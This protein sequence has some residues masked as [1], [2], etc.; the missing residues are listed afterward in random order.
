MN[1]NGVYAYIRGIGL[2]NLRP[3]F[4]GWFFN[5]V[6]SLLVYSGSYVV[7]AHS[8]GNNPA[9]ADILERIGLLNFLVDTSTNFPGNLSLLLFFAGVIVLL[10]LPASIFAAGGIYMVFIEDDKTTFTN[11]I[12]YS[13]ENFFRMLKMFLV[14]LFNWFIA[15][16]IPGL[17][18]W[19][20]YRLGLLSSENGKMIFLFAWVPL[21][22]LAWTV[23]TVIYDFSRIFKLIEDRNIFYSF[24]KALLFTFSNKINILIIFLLYAVSLGLFYLVHVFLMRLIENLVPCVF[25]FVVYQGFIITRYF[26]KIILMRAQVEYLTHRSPRDT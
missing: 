1:M 17:V 24:K 5:L 23:A 21:A 19:M 16:A 25:I 9:A 20:L 6:A 15:I 3:A 10:Y 7:F 4:F 13:L 26:L 14:N 8:I 2:K 11:L 18:L 22:V 12:A